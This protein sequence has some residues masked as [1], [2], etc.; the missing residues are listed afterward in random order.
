MNRKNIREFAA[1]ELAL[2]TS[3]YEFVT[4]FEGL[5]N[6]AANNTPKITSKINV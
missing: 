1:V 5:K 3:K 4:T 6:A 2:P